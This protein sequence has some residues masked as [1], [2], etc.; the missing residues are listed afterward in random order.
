MY[1]PLTQTAIRIVGL[2]TRY[3]EHVMNTNDAAVMERFIKSR[4]PA[5]PNNQEDSPCIQQLHTLIQEFDNEGIITFMRKQ[6]SG[7]LESFK[8]GSNVVG[9]AV[10]S[11]SLDVVKTLVSAGFDP[12]EDV[13]SF[14]HCARPIRLACKAGHLDIVKFLVEDHGVDVETRDSCL[15]EAPVFHALFNGRLNVVKYFV[16]SGDSTSERFRRVI[17]LLPCAVKSDQSAICEYLLSQGGDVDH[18]SAE[19][20]GREME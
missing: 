6:D 17:L 12:E 8:H 15:T 9:R 16:E 18:S 3:I 7:I 10:K 5:I 11:G 1:V 20:R 14:G 13:S 4:K 2:R 19:E